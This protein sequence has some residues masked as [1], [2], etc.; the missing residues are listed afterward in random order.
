MRRIKIWMLL[1]CITHVAKAQVVFTKE[2]FVQGNDTLRYRLL[3]PANYDPAHT[4]PLLVYLH[5]SG[6]RGSDNEALLSKLAPIFT[7][8]SFRNAY[9]CYL[10]VPQCPRGDAWVNFPDFPQSLHATDTATRAGRL[11]LALVEE[12]RSKANIDKRRVYLTGY[13]M[14]G[15][16]TLDLLARKPEMFAAAIALCP[17]ADTANAPTEGTSHI[18][19][20]GEPPAPI[21]Y[22][23]EMPQFIGDIIAYLSQHLRYPDAARSQNIEGKVII[24]FV[25][26]EDGSV[27]N[28]IVSRGI[29]GGCDE[30]AV[31]VVSGMPKWKPGK[32]MGKAVKVYYT[33][34]IRFTLE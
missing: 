30:E 2:L 23:E 6:Q 28:A 22:A 11:V 34:P 27:S 24:K 9:P 5:G 8:D 15:E 19:V 3:A 14:G 26:N 29:G 17:V 21:V 25:V 4:Y 32:H 13:S 10:L 18:V 1:V 12:M 31:R 20:P 33:L 16:G 7:S